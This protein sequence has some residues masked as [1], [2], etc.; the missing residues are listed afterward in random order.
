MTTPSPFNVLVVGQGALASALRALLIEHG[1]TVHVVSLPAAHILARRKR[2]DAAFVTFTM[3]APT[4]DLCAVFVKFGIS[5]VFFGPE[6]DA[7]TSRPRLRAMESAIE[8]S[9]T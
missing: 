4:A 5:F 8:L 9:S 1:A 3:D 6:A 7:P 2:I